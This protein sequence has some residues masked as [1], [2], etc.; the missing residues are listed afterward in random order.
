MF[1]LCGDEHPTVIN[2]LSRVSINPGQIRVR[3]SCVSEQGQ[4]SPQ[5]LKNDGRENG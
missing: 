2:F 1:H 4:N 5:R 3:V